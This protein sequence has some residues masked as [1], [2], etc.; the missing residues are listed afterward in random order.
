MN[1]KY[2]RYIKPYTW[3]FLLLV[4]LI[5]LGTAIQSFFPYVT[6]IIIDDV[7][8][9]EKFDLLLKILLLIISLAFISAILDIGKNLLNTYVAEKVVMQ[10]KS[11]FAQHI[12]GLAYPFYEKRSTGE[13]VS[14]FQNDTMLISHLMKWILPSFVQTLTQVI[15][16]LIILFSLSWKLTLISLAIVP[17][18]FIVNYFIAKPLKKI[19]Y[20]IQEQIAVNSEKIS[21]SLHA[22]KEILLFNRQN[23]DILRLKKS[24]QRLIPLELRNTYIRSVSVSINTLSYWIIFALLYWFGSHFVQSEQ[25]TLGTLVAFVTYIMSLFAP[26]NHLSLLYADIQS[27]FGGLQRIS[28]IMNMSKPQ[29]YPSEQGNIDF[30][31]QIELRNVTFSYTD[32]VSTLHDVSCILP[33]GKITA[34]VG[35]SGAGKSTLIKLLTGLYLPNKGEILIGNHSLQSCSTKQFR[36][37]IGVVLQENHFFSGSVFDN[38]LFGDLLASKQDIYHA[39][40][41][42][43]A[44]DFISD[45]PEGY[46]TNMGENGHVLSGGQKQRIALARALVRKPQVLILDEATSALDPHSEYLVNKGLLTQFR[47]KMTTIL[48]AHRIESIRHADYIIVLKDGKVV[49]SGTYTELLQNGDEFCKIYSQE[50]DNHKAK[51]FV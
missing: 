32:G 8:G 6:K 28:E 36:E 16:S 13:L 24:F 47:N 50:H 48:V 7:F 44:H 5:F 34:I 20:E 15:I 49:E 10:V 41:I 21:E 42:A 31:G 26:I 30:S 37:Q 29:H 51:Q 33:K 1:R 38:V 25:L 9:K 18:P 27:S 11:D 39:C 23:W 35:E 12:R 17:I 19:S 40:K 22:T 46:L 14:V 4:F 43:Q 3:F 45:L 2:W